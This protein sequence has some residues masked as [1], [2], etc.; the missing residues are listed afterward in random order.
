[1]KE[2]VVAIDV[3]S[4][5]KPGEAPHKDRMD[6][7]CKRDVFGKEM[8]GESEYIYVGNKKFYVIWRNAKE[9]K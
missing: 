3:H 7:I 5:F 2:M 8:D 1:M 9:G 6:M 4:M